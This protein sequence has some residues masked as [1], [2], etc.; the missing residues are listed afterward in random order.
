MDSY[1]AEMCVYQNLT[2]GPMVLSCL[3]FLGFGGLDLI[4]SALILRSRRD[5][6]RYSL[7]GVLTMSFTARCSWSWTS[8]LTS[9]WNRNN[10]S[11][12][13]ALSWMNLHIGNVQYMAPV[14]D[15][16]SGC[17]KVSLH[18]V[19]DWSFFPSGCGL[20]FSLS[21]FL[22]STQ[23]SGN[24]PY[25]KCKWFVD[26]CWLTNEDRKEGVESRGDWNVYARYL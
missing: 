21:L 5:G 19:F 1:T 15:K 11:F 23:V 26:T 8:L 12:V 18:P 9:L 13:A 3:I 24:L 7:A 6:N 17:L 10:L 25:C 14:W 16:F 20:N 2:Q 22:F 4:W